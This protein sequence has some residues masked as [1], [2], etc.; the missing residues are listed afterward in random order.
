MRI[1][2]NFLLLLFLFLVLSNSQESR[3]YGFFELLDVAKR[4]SLTYREYLYYKRNAEITLYL[5]GLQ[6]RWDDSGSLSGA[7][8]GYVRHGFELKESSG[9][10]SVGYSGSRKLPFNGELSTKVDYTTDGEGGDKA[11]ASLSLSFPLLGE[12]GFYY[13]VERKRYRLERELTLLN[14]RK[15][16][17]EFYMDL[18]SKYIA[19]VQAKAE[20][21]IAENSL[22]VSRRLYEAAQ[23]KYEAG[24]V[25][26]VEVS[27]AKV[28][29]LNAKKRLSEAERKYREMLE[30]LRDYVGLEETPRIR[31]DLDFHQ[32]PQLTEKDLERVMKNSVDIISLEMKRL[33]IVAEHRQK[34][35]SRLPTVSLGFTAGCTSDYPFEEVE[36]S[37]GVSLNFSYDFYDPHKYLPLSLEKERYALDLM[38]LKSEEKDVRRGFEQRFRQLKER[39]EELEMLR[40]SLSEAKSNLEKTLEQYNQGLVAYI[41]VLNAQRD[42]D[43]LSLSYSS[44]RWGYFNDYMQF[45][46]DGG[47]D[48]MSFIKSVLYYRRGEE[49]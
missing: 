13:D 38:E 19:A 49:K 15:R 3:V 29:F 46:S 18:L 21:S 1:K 4:S 6:Y 45:L 8:S 42:Y 40:E 5:E 22:E 23:L 47:V 35:A 16:E 14:I 48:I 28:N 44:E 33:S 36:E 27:R 39:R 32:L 11:S 34:R 7:W 26:E 12:T 24:L 20:L 30:D 25:A 2:K 43:S 10:L 31:D 37:Y 17:N 9:S 41:D